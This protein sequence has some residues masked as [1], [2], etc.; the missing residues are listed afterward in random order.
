MPACSRCLIEVPLGTDRCPKCGAVIRPLTLTQGGKASRSRP[1][2][3]PKRPGKTRQRVNA[4]NSK[5]KVVGPATLVLL[6]S[7]WLPWFTFGPIHISGVG[8]HGW[9]FIAV[10]NCIVLVLYVLIIAF[11]VGDLAGPGRMSKDQ[12]LAVLTGVYVALVVLGI[13]F[14]PAVT[15]WSWG[16]L[17]ALAASIVAFLPYGVPA[18]REQRGR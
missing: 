1:R 18:I 3:S 12:L 11:D 13:L 17:L 4:L 9:L 5:E 2:S 10:V 6:I 8:A 16:A 15:S 14:K 7:F